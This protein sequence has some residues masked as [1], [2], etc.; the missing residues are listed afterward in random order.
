M[1]RRLTFL[2]SRTEPSA[3]EYGLIAAALALAIGI[4]LH[5]FA[6]KIVAVLGWVVGA[7]R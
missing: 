6:G 2:P 7:A 5:G 3:T 4:S 1:R